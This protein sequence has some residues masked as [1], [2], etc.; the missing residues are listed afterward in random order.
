MKRT[1]KPIVGGILDIILGVLM[2]TGLISE[3]IENNDLLLLFYLIL[4][5]ALLV[6]G[7][8]AIRRRL[9]WV[10]LVGSMCGLFPGLIS[11]ALIAFSKGEFQRTSKI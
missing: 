7:I 11:T 10:A 8:C 3:S 1:W 9:W 6:G 4:P 5:V 2:F